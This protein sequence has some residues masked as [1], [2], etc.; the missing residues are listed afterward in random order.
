MCEALA[1]PGCGELGELRRALLARGVSGLTAE[2][3]ALL[4]RVTEV[5]AR[6]AGAT[7]ASPLISLTELAPEEALARLPPTATNR[8]YVV[9]VQIPASDV[10]RV[11]E[12]LPA[13]SERPC[14]S[15]QNP[16]SIIASSTRLG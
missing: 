9:R 15:H 6:V 14:C 13:A 7:P 10:A 16:A 5:H 12:L 1:Q 8:A 4:Q 2:E 3:A 11:N